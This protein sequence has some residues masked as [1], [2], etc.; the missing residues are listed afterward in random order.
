MPLRSSVRLLV[1]TTKGLFLI[2]PST[3]LQGPL[4]PGTSVPSVAFDARHQRLFASTTN[5]FWGTAIVCSDDLGHTWSQPPTP[6]IQFPADTGAAIRQ[7]WQIA[8]AGPAQPDLVYVGV[9]PAALFRSVDAG[10]TFELMRGLWDHPHR[11][12]WTPGQGGL[13]LHTILV[14]PR[15]A[16]KIV[17]AIST[18][19]VYRSDDGGETWR[20]S[21]T[22]VR[23]D[24]LP[25]KHPEYGQCVHKI[26]RDAVHPDTLYLQNHWGLYRSDDGGSNWTDI[27]NGVP[28]DFGF[29]IVAHP[30]KSGTAYIIPLVADAK[31]WTPDARCRVYRTTTGGGA[32]EPLTCGLPQRDA[33]ITVLRDA[34]SADTLDPAGL[35]FGTRG[36][37]LYASA[38]DGDDWELLAEHLPPVLSVRA[39]ILE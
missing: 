35:Y 11:P 16:L 26:A 18:G 17:V 21:N 2:D 29:P 38:N 33:Y 14:D 39:A 37:Q 24:F 34:F 27:A 13:G 8:P 23:A 19:G 7:V 36:G 10:E 31:R 1:G 3:A 12:T 6:N 32:W 30:H 25:D 22:G 4:L 15:D 28:S 9:E 5:P 20:A